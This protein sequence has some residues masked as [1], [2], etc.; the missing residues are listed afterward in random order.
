MMSATNDNKGL[1]YFRFLRHV[2]LLERGVPTI[3]IAFCS[4]D[5]FRKSHKN[6][7]LNL[8]PFQCFGIL[9]PL[10]I[11]GL[12]R[13]IDVVV[14]F[15]DICRAQLFAAS[16][17]TQQTSKICF[18]TISHLINVDSDLLKFYTKLFH[19]T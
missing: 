17:S 14:T 12:T 11:R 3:S 7:L 15:I 5:I 9:P 19:K 10:A 4:P 6:A 2:G 13:P 1:A 18:L 16:H 8:W